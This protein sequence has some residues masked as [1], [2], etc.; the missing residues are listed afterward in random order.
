MTHKFLEQF[1][2]HEGNLYSAKFVKPF[3]HYW[4]SKGAPLL[5]QVV[6]YWWSFWWGCPFHWPNQL[7]R[8]PMWS[9]LSPF[10]A[11]FALQPP[12]HESPPHDS[13]HKSNTTVNRI[14]PITVKRLKSHDAKRQFTNDNGAFLEAGQKYPRFP[15]KKFTNKNFQYC[16]FGTAHLEDRFVIIFRISLKEWEWWQ[17]NVRWDDCDNI[18]CS[19]LQRNCV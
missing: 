9:Q 18:T 3:F 8:C 10:D 16:G 14:S 1:M 5:L 15:L 19:L 11:Y 13:L 4:Q 6:Q 12:S 2:W 17:K 7:N